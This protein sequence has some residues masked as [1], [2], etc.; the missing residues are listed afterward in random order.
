MNT[1]ENTAEFFS[2]RLVILKAEHS[3]QLKALGEIER[4]LATTKREA[5][6]AAADEADEEQEQEEALLTSIKRR[7]LSILRTIEC[8]V[9][10]VTKEAEKKAALV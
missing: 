6:D 2:K 4:L 1:Y 9:A 3:R 8:A 7:Q 5:E 10:A